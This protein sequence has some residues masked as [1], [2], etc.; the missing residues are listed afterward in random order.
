MAFQAS[1][2]QETRL[3][4]LEEVTARMAARYG[5]AVEAVCYDASF[6]PQ[7]GKPTGAYRL[8]DPDGDTPAHVSVSVHHWGNTGKVYVLV[9]GH[10]NEPVRET[11]AGIDY[12]LIV[13]RLD[14]DYRDTLAA[15]RRSDAAL[16]AS[17]AL[18]A[19]LAAVDM[20]PEYGWVSLPG[21]D[22]TVTSDGERVR[23]TLTFG[24]PP[25]HVAGALAALKVWLAG[26]SLGVHPPEAAP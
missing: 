12:G 17:E 26:H 5:D 4:V 24:G 14:R 22:A 20:R 11:K 25:D 16:A 6:G 18:R 3:R 8:A 1:T 2:F 21:G 10:R 19:A 7:A 13:E 15:R 9:S 23:V